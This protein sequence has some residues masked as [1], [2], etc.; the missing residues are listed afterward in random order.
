MGSKAI[1]NNASPITQATGKYIK[2]YLFNILKIFF[3]MT[4]V[5]FLIIYLNM[6]F[7]NRLKKRGYRITNAR[8]VICTILENSGH[9][10]FTAEQL[11]TE[12]MK[13]DKN[14]DLATVYRTLEVLE[15]IEIIEHSH[16]VHGSGIFYLKNEYSNFHII[17]EACEK[18]FDL[19]KSTSKKINDLLKEDSNFKDINNHF[20][21]SGQCKNCN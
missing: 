15:D 1:K 5:S 17:C 8:E 2:L 21:Y 14:I 12:S 13:R 3:F 19:K 9:K 11:H 16:Q 20:I 10:H 18:I 6:D 4:S 7:A